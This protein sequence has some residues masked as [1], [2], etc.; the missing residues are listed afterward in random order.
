M[1]QQRPSWPGCTKAARVPLLFLLAVL[2]LTRASATPTPVTTTTTTSDETDFDGTTDDDGILTTDNPDDD[3]DDGNSTEEIGNEK[4]DWRKGALIYHI[5]PRAFQDSDGDGEGDLQGIISRLDYLDDLGVDAIRLG[6]IFASAGVD[7]GYDILNHTDIDDTYGDFDDFDELVDEAHK[8]GLKIILDVVPNHSSD[9]HEWFISSAA[10]EEPYD[11]YYIWADGKVVDNKVVPP[12]NWKSS[13]KDDEGSAWTWH[14]KRRQWYYHKLDHAEPD[15]NLRN[16]DVIQEIM[17]IV[18]FWLEKEVDGFCIHVGESENADFLYRL[19]EHIDQW[20]LDN[21]AEPKLLLGEIDEL[22]DNAISYYGND[23]QPGLIPLSLALITKINDTSD[24][25]DIKDVIEDWMEK[26]P[27]GAI[28][29]WQLSSQDYSRAASRLNSDLLD[30]LYML[31]LL[32][33]GQTVTYYGEEIGMLNTNI[34]W[35]ET[36]DI[37]GLER[38]EDTYDDYSRDP[39]RTPMQWND[40]TSAGFS[41][42]ETTYL[43]VNPN[44]VDIN[45]DDELDQ[46]NS[47]LRAYKRLALLRQNPIFENGDWELNAVNDDQVLIL[48][49]SL[50]NDTC[51]A[52]INFGSSKEVV[53]LTS[54]Y[55]DLE[56]DLQVMVDSSNVDVEED[57]F[58]D[59]PID[60]DT[61]ATEG[62]DDDEDDAKDENKSK[63]ESDED[64]SKSSESEEKDSKEENDDDDEEEPSPDSACPRN[65]FEYFVAIQMA[66]MLWLRL[67]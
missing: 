21:G 47:N 61:D 14:P 60:N 53:N 31:T 36:I 40:T 45:V 9:Q 24:A 10:E 1:R 44:Y 28:S 54:L 38:T 32:L 66:L 59:V 8:K 2:L 29:S 35:H 37:R 51:L 6:P 34:S 11:D 4:E 5:L 7:S 50:D 33:P 20:V 57:D 41:D 13:Y 58:P 62:D 30:G 18:D 16:E 27:E 25:G 3:D 15:L 52:I 39:F 42:N 56:E 67:L 12:T 23:T 43:P 22:D 19:R 48:K 64:D 49:R 26:L 17:G 65:T 63:D 55:P 46:P